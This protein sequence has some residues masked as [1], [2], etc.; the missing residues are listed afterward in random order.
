MYN[1]IRTK[2]IMHP[3]S[4]VG[5]ALLETSMRTRPGGTV[6]LHR[7]KAAISKRGVILNHNP[8]CWDC[9]HP[10]HHFAYPLGE[11]II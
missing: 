2:E 6:L 10:R 7:G 9:Y 11:C 5:S 8:G 1:A 3:T 4:V